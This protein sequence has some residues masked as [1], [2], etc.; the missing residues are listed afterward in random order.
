MTIALTIINRDYKQTNNKGHAD[1]RGEGQPETVVPLEHI[2][3]VANLTLADKRDKPDE[4][5]NDT[6]MD[7]IDK[8]NKN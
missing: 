5:S 4:K 7:Q 6:Q 1:Q 8:M 3:M 2:W